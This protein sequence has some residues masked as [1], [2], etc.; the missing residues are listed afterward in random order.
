[1]ICLKGYNQQLGSTKDSALIKFSVVDLENKPFATKVFFFGIRNKKNNY[2]CEENTSKILLPNNN[3]YIVYSKLL[4][5]S[6]QLPIT[7][8]VNQFYRFAFQFDNSQAY[9]IHPTPSEAL[10]LFK[11]LNHKKQPQIQN[12]TIIEKGTKREFKGKTGENGILKI[13]LPNNTEYSVSIGSSANYSSMYPYITQV[14]L[15]YGLNYS[16][17]EPVQFAMFN[18]GGDIPTSMKPIGSTN[19]V[20][21]CINC[22][23]DNLTDSLYAV[24][25]KGRSGDGSG[26]DIEAILRAAQNVNKFKELIL[27]ADN[28]STIRDISLLDKIKVPVRVIL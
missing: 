20:Y 3:T 13:L 16:K 14:E 26:N 5:E 19:G 6:Y 9:T 17:K 25:N 8:V 27:I 24:R 4:M 12:L 21:Y 28:Y 7:N 10:V 15:W 1:M 18:D 22:T 11:L 2:L 23:V